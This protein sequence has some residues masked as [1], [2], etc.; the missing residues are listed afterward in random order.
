MQTKDHTKLPEFEEIPQ[1]FSGFSKL[2]EITSSDYYSGIILPSLEDVE[3]A[4]RI[5]NGERSPDSAAMAT[6][7][8]LEMATLRHYGPVGFVMLKQAEPKM[9]EQNESIVDSI[10]K[11]AKKRINT[12]WG[13]H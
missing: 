5:F 7:Q 2:I 13:Y 11:G 8:N 9:A 10:M 4:L 1:S 6:Q 12:E 3:I